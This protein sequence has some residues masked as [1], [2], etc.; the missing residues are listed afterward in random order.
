ME[1]R[2]CV[3]PT[4]EL[5]INAQPFAKLFWKTTPLRAIEN[6]RILYLGQHRLRA[7]VVCRSSLISLPYVEVMF[8][9]DNCLLHV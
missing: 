7:R 5:A 9:S 2:V 4:P 1:Q 3:R 6:R 8:H